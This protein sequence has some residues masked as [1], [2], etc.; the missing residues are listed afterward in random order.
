MSEDSKSSFVV[1]R[2]CKRSDMESG[3]YDLIRAEAPNI[4][5]AKELFDHANRRR[6]D[7]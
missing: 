7:G 1:E 4:E 3:E 5:D 2:R 6:N